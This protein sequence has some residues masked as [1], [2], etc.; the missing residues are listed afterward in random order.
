MKPDDGFLVL[1][2][3]GN[4]RIDDGSELFGADTL[5][6][7]GQKATS[8][9]ETL[10]DLDSN[11]DRLFDAADTRFADVR[12]W[13]DLNRDGRSQYNELFILSSLGVAWITLIPRTWTWVT[14]TSSITA[15]P[16]PA[17][18]AAPAWAATCNEAST[19]ATVM[20]AVLT[21]R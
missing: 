16:T 19:T 7:N 20:P 1:D 6:R 8:G 13:R 9:F 10:R 17:P 14:A 3:N 21:T 2:R 11:A 12:V 5:L 4:G 18:M 15:A